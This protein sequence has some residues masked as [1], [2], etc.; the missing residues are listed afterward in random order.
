M[1]ISTPQANNDFTDSA[2][3]TFSD[4]WIKGP[5]LSTIAPGAMRPLEDGQDGIVL[6]N[7]AG[8]I[9]AFRNACL[10]QGLPIHAGDLTSSGLLL[11]PWHNWCYDVRDGACLTAPGACLEQFS[12]RIED[13]HIWVSKASPQPV[14]T[15]GS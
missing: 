13:G 4:N 8:E 2:A 11:C 9:T 7:F 12:V 5:A 10:H 14:R 1:T 15:S 6:V 3:A